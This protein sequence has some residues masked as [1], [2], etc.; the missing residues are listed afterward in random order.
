MMNDN[1]VKKIENFPYLPR[2]ALKPFLEHE[3]WFHDSG[4]KIT[5]LL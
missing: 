2:H 5:L 4:S 3:H 1:D